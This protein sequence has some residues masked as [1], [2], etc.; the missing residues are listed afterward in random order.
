MIRYGEEHYGQR[1]QEWIEKKGFDP[2]TLRND[3]WVASRI[4]LPHRRA[5][6]S[7][8]HHIEVAGLEPP[9]QEKLLSQAEENSVTRELL[10]AEKQQLVLESRQHGTPPPD[11]ALWLDQVRNAA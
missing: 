5:T 7:Y 1:Y 6:L 2:Q 3:K 11:N 10:R 9:E 8:E 4:E